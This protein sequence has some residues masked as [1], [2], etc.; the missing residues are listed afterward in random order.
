MGSAIGSRLARVCLLSR[1]FPNFGPLISHSDVQT[2]DF[3]FWILIFGFAALEIWYPT[4]GPSLIERGSFLK[5]R[6][7]FEKNRIGQE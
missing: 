1:S 5:R 4:L 6:R 7:K 2:S 3:G